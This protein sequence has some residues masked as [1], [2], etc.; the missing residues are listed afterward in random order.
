MKHS[1]V[2]KRLGY[3]L[4]I[5]LISIMSSF[6]IIL[7]QDL[8]FQLQHEA[9]QLK[10]IK[11]KA[12]VQ[13][14]KINSRIVAELQRMKSA[15]DVDAS[16]RIHNST[17]AASLETNSHGNVHLILRSTEVNSSLLA[18][19]TK[20]GFEVKATTENL[21]ISPNLH[22]IS[23][24]VP[25][26]RV[27]EI[28]QLEQIFHIRPADRPISLGGDVVTE[29]D[30]ILRSNLARQSFA[31]EGA[32]Q[33]I[34]VISN[35]IDHLIQSQSSDDLPSNIEILSNRF[36][37]DEGTAMLEIIHDIA[38]GAR[39]GFADRGNS[40]TDF[41]NNITLLKNA[42][43]TI[44]CDDILFPLEPV[45]EDG[46][47]AQTIDNIVSN[48]NI[49]YIAAAG[50]L[51]LDHYENDFID[52]D[53]DGWHN[54]AVNDETMNIQLPAG[55]EITAVL[56]WNNQFGKSGDDYDLFIYNE[57]LSL[58]LASSSDTQDGNDDP[59]EKIVYK[60]SKSTPITIHLGI[61]NF[62]GQARNLSV[63]TF[64]AGVTPQ[65]YTGSEGAI[66]GHA[67][68]ENCIAVAAIDAN[69]AGN[70]DI[71][72]TSSHGPTRIYAYDAMG[73]PISFVNRQKPDHASID[74]VTTKVGKLGYF[75][76]PFYGTSAAA[77]H[78]AGI[79]ALLGEAGPDVIAS[80]LSTIMN[81]TAIDLG[82][83][84]FDN[85][86]GHGRIDAFQAVSYL[87]SIAPHISVS[88]DSISVELEKGE[89]TT[90]QIII[91]NT[92]KSDLNFRLSWEA[93]SLSKMTGDGSSELLQVLK[94]HPKSNYVKSL[95]QESTHR[96]SPTTRLSAKKLTRASENEALLYEGFEAGIIPPNG[97][98]KIDGPSTPGGTSPAHWGVDAANYIFSGQYSAVCSWG[99]N[100]D[101][102]L[103]TPGL[104][105]SN[106]N[107]PA[108]SFWWMS[109]YFWNVSPND[110]GDLFVKAS[111]DGG[112]TW[113]TL[114]TFGNI[115]AWDD[116][117]WYYSIIDLS[118]YRGKS[119]VKIAFN[120]VA[121]DNADI[122][123]DEIAVFGDIGKP[124]WVQIDSVS[125]TVAPGASQVIEILIRSVVE[126][127]TLAAGSYFGN[128]HVSSNAGNQPSMLVPVN[129]QVT[130]QPDIKGKLK[131][132]GAHDAAVDSATVR[133]TGDENNSIVSGL[134]GAY[135]FLSLN[136]GSYF[137]I[138]GKN[139]D[140]RGA[141]TP[142]DAS[143]ILQN[144]VGLIDLTPYQKIAG[145]V[146]GNGAVT[147]Y[148]ASFILQHT[149]NP[150]A[151]FPIEKQWIFVPHDFNINESNWSAAPDSRTYSP[152]NT[153]KTN[154]DFLG[155][156]YGDVS[157]NWGS[158]DIA[159]TAETVQI[160]LME[161]EQQN[162][163]K[164]VLPVSIE[165]QNAAY[166][167]FIK[168]EF[169]RQHLNFL[170]C[171]KDFQS[172]DN[173]IIESFNLADIINVAV[174]AGEPFH[175]NRLK[176]Q[177]MFE[178]I[179]QENFSISDFRITEIRIDG[180]V[181]LTTTIFNNQKAEHPAIWQL[182][183]NY[184][185]PFNSETSI[186]YTIPEASHVKLIIYNL[187]GQRL[188]TLVD[189]I[190]QPGHHRAIWNGIDERK[191]FIGS[192]VYIYKIEAGSFGATKKMVLLP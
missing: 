9:E 93:S 97:W 28:A 46:I 148:D 4:L 117:V 35:G 80:K 172:P 127:D 70:N 184:P 68:A 85:I 111:T 18:A 13:F 122:A 25:L 153:D 134:D 49:L 114:W 11:R 135:E 62:G 32:G 136:E 38:P 54:F 128:I 92:G 74:G 65:Q 41:I 152:L 186:Q 88:P 139:N 3:V 191:R 51:Q 102:W 105:F 84:G 52:N 81:T 183:Q 113:K 37:G 165:F 89:A 176:I 138:P 168:M 170:S 39:L 158:A 29:G 187:M 1:M 150:G 120:V 58:E 145:D 64:G 22:Q 174:A 124:S 164:L 107:N 160:S 180:K 166:S 161:I 79:A 189:G 10:Q 146:T 142:Y 57:Q 100:L 123:V 43:C 99:L 112:R 167:G 125:G 27:E 144:N 163:G 21:E 119:N 116:F 96:N 133:L 86:F 182:S 36:T 143:L 140:I 40:E 155:I 14:R 101:E 90:R 72:P 56:Q 7:A 77:A 91:D 44:I 61:K 31:I 83:S 60:N 126:Q 147:P 75:A 98:N 178:Q 192:G 66:Y 121:S 159:S 5:M 141:I 78:T 104:D 12:S 179:G 19:L 181:C 42:G 106:I 82:A 63:Y 6:K 131:Y 137:V 59:V 149:V 69:D 23:G 87:I 76:N 115:G 118:A 55:A 94:P 15:N 103:V 154:Q 177:F 169:N 95:S 50:N 130:S 132:F 34:G 190:K 110:N 73:N 175:D 16:E 108:M 156:L 185:N 173:T 33:K 67:A 129:L 109:S 162:D 157:G 17:S 48:H 151:K 188:N 24:W 53:N 45:Y 8:P 30:A 47:V 71:E 2:S 20:K 26:N 171:I